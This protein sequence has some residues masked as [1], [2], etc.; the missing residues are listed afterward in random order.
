M[1]IIIEYYLIGNSASY[2]E[3]YYFLQSVYNAYM[4]DE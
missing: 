3:K 1:G 4:V 2:L